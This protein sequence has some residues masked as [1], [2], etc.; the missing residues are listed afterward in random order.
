MLP[1]SRAES[2]QCSLVPA[3]LECMPQYEALSYSWGSS[4]DQHYTIWIDDVPV[5]I[6]KNLYQALLELRKPIHPRVI[7]A[8]AICI[9]QSDLLERASQIHQMG[10]IYGQ[11]DEVILWIGPAS[12]DSSVA[13]DFVH[14]INTTMLS[15]GEEINPD[16]YKYSMNKF[17][18][19]PKNQLKWEALSSLC[20]RMYWK[21]RW[22]IQEIALAPRCIIQCGDTVLDWRA[23]E[24]VCL[25]IHRPNELPSGPS[26]LNSIRE[27]LAVKHAV[28]RSRRR[29]GFDLQ[30][31]LEAFE[32]SDCKE[33]RDKIYAIL[34]LIEFS[35]SESLVADYKKALFE[36]YVDVVWFLLPFY[37]SKTPAGN[38]YLE[39]P[40]SIVRI[41]QFVQRNLGDVSAGIERGALEEISAALSIPRSVA[42]GVTLIQGLRGGT[43]T[44]MRP[45]KPHLSAE[46][47]AEEFRNLLSY[48]KRSD[49][50]LTRTEILSNGLD[51]FDEPDKRRVVSFD[52]SISYGEK[53]WS[54]APYKRRED[55]DQMN[56]SGML[57][58]IRGAFWRRR[59]S[60][61]N[62]R[63]A[64]DVQIFLGEGDMI[65]IAPAAA[66]DGDMICHFLNCDAAAVMRAQGDTFILVGRALVFPRERS[67]STRLN[68]WTNKRFKYM[69]PKEEDLPP[70]SH[71]ISF[72]S[73]VATLQ[74]LTK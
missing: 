44:H 53:G 24:N 16:L 64:A 47:V 12:E 41:S 68:D 10:K 30:F 3:S 51:K 33:A 23:F 63:P 61:L 69:I 11:A 13:M 72:Y 38:R 28:L 21:R 25:E 62:V 46:V 59:S 4:T 6:R 55:D 26:I 14:E 42:T 52:S 39:F 74:V 58:N 1:G 45:Y 5:S 65:G 8:D 20:D 9:N 56:E 2:I 35:S 60:S 66:K 27:S 29:K 34:A 37:E 19:N 31:I 7:W 49:R 57:S 15:E 48:H 54:P 18:A 43:I 22:I 17:S 50:S 32:D 73:D 71:G 70:R 36:V 40:K 67:G